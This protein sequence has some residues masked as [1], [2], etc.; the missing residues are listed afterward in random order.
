MSCASLKLS[1]PEST[2]SKTSAI[3]ASVC[4]S[5]DELETSVE[6]TPELELSVVIESIK[7]CASSRVKMPASTSDKMSDTSA[8]VSE[9]VSNDDTEN[10]L[11]LEASSLD[12]LE[13]VI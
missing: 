5:D 8:S 4:P 9:T 13:A 12:E 3:S 11:E 1:S 2:Y 6:L 7:S 10:S